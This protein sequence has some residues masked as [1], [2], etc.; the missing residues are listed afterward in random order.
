MRTG[1]AA[2]FETVAASPDSA[3]HFVSTASV[4]M[5]ELSVSAQRHIEVRQMHS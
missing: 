3:R 4:A 5:L 1:G 2:V